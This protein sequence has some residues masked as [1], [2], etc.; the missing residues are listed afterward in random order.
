M[1]A[2]SGHYGV[3]MFMAMVRRSDL[4]FLTELIEAGKFTLEPEVGTSY[5][6]GFAVAVSSARA[7]LRMFRMA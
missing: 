5:R 7:P 3:R 1:D 4:L 6:D 2:V